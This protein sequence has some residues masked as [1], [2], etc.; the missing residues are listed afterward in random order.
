MKSCRH[1]ADQLDCASKLS[2]T[3]IVDVVFLLLVFFVFAFEPM[4]V[5][6][7]LNADRPGETITS[8]PPAPPVVIT[9]FQDRYLLNG[10]AEPFRR[11]QQKF[12]RLA[13]RDVSPGIR[14][15]C[16]SEAQHERLI[17]ILNL[18]EKTRLK[19]ITLMSR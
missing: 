2:T 7:I 15:I 16:D 8:P 3:A 13:E 18:C 12:H 11:L 6:A 9:I 10:R 17:R 19:N 1:R 4:D 5:H 14:I